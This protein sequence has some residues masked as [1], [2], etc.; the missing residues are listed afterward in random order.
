[1][2]NR[3]VTSGFL[4]E[5][6]AGLNRPFM[7]LEAVF[8]AT[9]LRY[10]TLSSDITWDSKTWLGDGTFKALPT[11]SESSTVVA[12]GITVELAGE[13][14][15]LISTLLNNASHNSTGKVWLGFLNSSRQ[16][17]ADPKQI[18]SGKLNTAP[19]V[20]GV[21]V[22]SIKLNYESELINVLN[23]NEFR[24][25]LKT[26]QITYPSDTGFKYMEALANWSGYWGKKKKKKKKAKK[27]RGKD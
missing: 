4:A 22:A 15:V 27:N 20:D 3:Q 25:N 17:I 12:A 11:V 8:G 7:L 13:P 2:G 16:V 10:N 18:F 1:M 9:V 14:A 23:N 21:D 24:Y 19:F 26:Q 5:L 6:T